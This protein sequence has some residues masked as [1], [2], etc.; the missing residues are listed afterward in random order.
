M[1]VEEIDNECNWEWKL[2]EIELETVGADAGEGEEGEGGAEAA[3]EKELSSL[4]SPSLFVLINNHD[5]TAITRAQNANESESDDLSVGS[6]S[7]E[8]HVSALFHALQDDQKYT[9]ADWASWDG[10]EGPVVFGLI[11][12]TAG[13]GDIPPEHED[14]A[15]RARGAGRVGDHHFLQHVSWMMKYHEL[16]VR[17]SQH[18]SFSS[19]SSPCLL[20]RALLVLVIISITIYLYLYLHMN[21]RC[22][23]WSTGMQMYL[24]DIK[25]IIP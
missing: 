7:A 23:N 17:T 14:S 18:L 6:T 12:E 20:K 15:S 8:T 16:K 4:I 22:L 13:G 10:D 3:K 1:I 9:T 5:S 19:R 2:E 11:S 24:R 21:F 25:R